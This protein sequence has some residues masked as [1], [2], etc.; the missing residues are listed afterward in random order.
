VDHLTSSS[1]AGRVLS[2]GMEWP[3]SEIDHSPPCQGEE[4]IK[5]Y[6]YSTHMLS[7]SKQGIYFFKFLVIEIG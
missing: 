3:G 5:R 7:W 2:L 6:L 4:C 1:I